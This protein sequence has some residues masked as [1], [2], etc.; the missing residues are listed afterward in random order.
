MIFDREK[1]SRTRFT[2]MCIAEAAVALMKNKT[3]KELKVLEVVKK[4]GVSRMTFYKYYA[5]IQEAL[6]DY[7]HII[8]SE[9][10]E[11][12]G[13][14][15]LSYEH[16][17]SALLFFDRYRTFFLTMKEQG[18]YSVLMDSVNEFMLQHIH[19]R[20]E[21]SAYKIYSYA[22]SLLNCFLIWEQ[23]GRKDLASDVAGMMYELYGNQQEIE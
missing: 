11:E 6:E 19:H 15:F 2:R 22:G 18:L 1:T 9:Y 8:I 5:N 21:M 3:L 10:L 16:I 20:H 4:A 13:Q 23:E 17:L 14:D 12:C 7:L